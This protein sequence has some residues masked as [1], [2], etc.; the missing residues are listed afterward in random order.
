MA[1]ITKKHTNKQ[2]IHHKYS[3]MYCKQYSLSAVW[4]HTPPKGQTTSLHLNSISI[5]QVQKSQC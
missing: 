4:L 2:D 3:N 5:Q 1:K